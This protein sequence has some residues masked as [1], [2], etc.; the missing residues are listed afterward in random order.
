MI[1]PRFILIPLDWVLLNEIGV[2]DLELGYQCL[3]IETLVFPS[4]T[5]LHVGI[6]WLSSIDLEAYS[7]D[8]SK[9]VSNYAEA[10]NFNQ[11][12]TLN[13]IVSH[14]WQPKCT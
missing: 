7:I 2:I 6:I 1:P 4:P 10:L 9:M 14:M 8:S 12:Y 3:G 5:G 13:S 11:I